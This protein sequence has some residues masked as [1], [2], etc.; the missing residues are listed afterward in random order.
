MS[1]S[2]SVMDDQDTDYVTIVPKDGDIEHKFEEVVN[3]IENKVISA[4]GLTLAEVFQ[5]LVQMLN[6]DLELVKKV[7]AHA[8]IMA[9]HGMKVA[10]E[11]KLRKADVRR[12]LEGKHSVINMQNFIKA[13]PIPPAV[14][15]PTKKGR[16]L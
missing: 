6:G 1:N 7:L 4:D 13:P 14:K 10:E 8:N 9:K 3:F 2:A 16:G 11:S 15:L 5:A 12:A